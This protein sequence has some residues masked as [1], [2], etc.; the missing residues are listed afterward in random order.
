MIEVAC[1][2]LTKGVTI[3]C[4]DIENGDF[5]NEIQGN[6]HKIENLII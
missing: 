6:N 1:R 2:L 5:L 3:T 4:E